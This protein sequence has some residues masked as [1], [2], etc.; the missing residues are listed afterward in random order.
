MPQLQPARPTGSGRGETVERILATAERLFAEHGFDAV[1][2]HSIAEQAGVSKAN[3][4]H[5][6]T[7]KNELY[8][9]VLRH[10]CHD[11]SQH[12]DDLGGDDATLAERLGKFAHAHLASLLEHGQVTRLSL[13]ELL[14]DDSRQSQEL[15]E[16]VYGEKFARFVAILRAG[17]DAGELRADIDPAMVATVLI[18]ANV[19][20]FEAR[21]V[22]RHLPE[23]TFSEQPERYSAMLADILLRGIRPASN[24]EETKNRAQP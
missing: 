23:V 22:L 24:S 9:A 10:A 15:A 11:A 16:K 21:D 20:F 5:H 1:S 3:V 4:F 8:I 13:R 6:F 19:F 12:L 14:N 7:S 2:M 17:Q 18:G